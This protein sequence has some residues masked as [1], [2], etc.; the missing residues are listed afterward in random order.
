[1][2]FYP[3]RY[4]ALY[5]VLYECS[6]R[7]CN[8]GEVSD[9]DNDFDHLCTELAHATAQ[10]LLETNS[11]NWFQRPGGVLLMVMSI[12]FSRGIPKT[13]GDMDDLTAKLTSNFGHC[14]Q[15][16]LNL[17]LTGQAGMCVYVGGC[18]RVRA[19]PCIA[20]HNY[21]HI[22]C[23]FILFIAS[24]LTYFICISYVRSHNSP[25]T[26]SNVFDHTLRP[27]GELIC[28]GLQFR[29][30]IGYL[31]QLEAMRYLEVG[32][33]YK[34]PRF[35]IW[36]IGS[37]SHFTV[38]FGDA[39]ALKESA[40]D[41]LL[42]RVRRAFKRMDGGAEENGFI[43]TSQLEDFLQSLGLTNI[44]EQGVQTL[45]ALIE[46]NGAGIILWEDLWKRTSRLLTGASLESILDADEETNNNKSTTPN[47]AVSDIPASEAGTNVVQLTDEE[48]A[49]KLQA[50]WN[51]EV[52]D[53]METSAITT[54]TTVP[55]TTLEK[56]GP[57]FQLYHYNGLRGGNFRAFRVTRLS[58]DEAIGA[59]ISLGVSNQ[60]SHNTGGFGGELDA[61]L[62]TKWPSCK[63]NWIGDNSP[64]SIN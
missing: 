60:S 51:G 17:L 9:N 54:P 18:T 6:P 13:Q 25:T 44:S 30:A 7:S 32:G 57:T 33:F 14:S 15:E 63:I 52:V 29:P 39:A 43:Q 2:I 26:V 16:L 46:V 42:E 41:I 35:P 58:A 50:E 3:Y 40:S 8:D 27:S 59:S 19:L 55:T 53:L 22:M 61:V 34:T 1:M 49:R 4:I 24:F 56:F 47:K 64:P 62:R 38:M 10:F 21:I 5:L 31:T 11:L 48:L 28:R 23:I 36:V 12:A 37:T 20:V 45:A